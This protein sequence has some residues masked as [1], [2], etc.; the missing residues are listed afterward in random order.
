MTEKFSILGGKVH[1]Y[2][3][4]ESPIWQCSAYLAGKNRRRSTKETSLSKAKVIAEDWFLELRGKNNR[5]EISNETTFKQAADRFVDEYEIITEGERNAKY[6][7]DHQARLRNHLI[8]YFGKMGLS[9]ITAGKV[10]DYRIM[11]MA[12]AENKSPPSRSFHLAPA[13]ISRIHLQKQML[14]H[15]CD[16]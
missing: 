9:E 15:V 3:R 12:S 8:P 2:K 13:S 14:L 6:V 11:R 16:A 1:V 10:Q 7:Q 4:P 5:G